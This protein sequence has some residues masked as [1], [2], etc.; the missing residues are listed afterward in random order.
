MSAILQK[1]L[2]YLLKEKKI[3]AHSLEKRIGL[4]LSAVQNILQGKSKKP[5]AEL[6]FA[7]AKELDCSVESLLK[8]NLLSKEEKNL[9][10]EK[11]IQNLYVESL[12]LVHLLIKKKELQ[13]TKNALL[14]LAEEVYLYSLKGDSG[15]ANRQFADWLVSR[16]VEK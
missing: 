11:W 1:N 2:S 4:K 3:S 5:S 14:E 9:S 16:H 10:T 6:L 12:D 13:I 7:I 15:T 8:D